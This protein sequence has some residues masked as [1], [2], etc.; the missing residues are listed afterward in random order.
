MP[1][2]D[3][4]MKRLGLDDSSLGPIDARSPLTGVL[5]VDDSPADR[6]LAS[7]I[8]GHRK[9]L[10]AITASD[11][12]E[13]L[14][15]MARDAPAVV[16]IGLQM[17][18]VNGLELVGAIRR[19]Y[20]GVPVI[21]MT[22]FASEEAAM[23]ARQVGAATY[24]SKKALA[25]DLV[26]TIDAV[27]A[28]AAVD[29]RRQKLLRSV[30]S[31]RSSYSLENDPELIAPLIAMLQED[32][33]EMGVCDA[34][35]RTRV[36]V[37]LQEAIANALFHGNLEVS[38]D[39]RQD[40]EHLFYAQAESR[41]RASPYRHR[42]VHVSAD[43]NREAATYRVRDEGSGFDTSTLD[44]PFDPESLLRVGG[45]G[46]L[47]IRTFMDEVVHNDAGNEITMIKKRT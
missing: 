8:V 2:L 34:N 39:L 19:L 21:V 10:R 14:E 38:T 3:S 25:R 44:A 28:R 29:Q 20:P 11:G 30:Q 47:L 27:L 16:V 46:L 43:L 18:G 1:T 4:T 35:Q 22:A 23:H 17:P 32:L 37:A 12:R 9:G 33:A 7:A 26:D 45:R 13:A 31:S 41:R 5:I 6:R 24:L 36:G 40:D 15:R 42:R